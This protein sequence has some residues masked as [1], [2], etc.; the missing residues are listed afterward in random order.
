[1]HELQHRPAGVAPQ[2]QRLREYGDDPVGEQ[3][4]TSQSSRYCRVTLIA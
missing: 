2:V 4:G 1:M 3:C